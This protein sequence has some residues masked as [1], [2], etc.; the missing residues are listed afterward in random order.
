VEIDA[1]LEN[2][3]DEAAN[4]VR[5][6][7]RSLRENDDRLLVFILE[8]AHGAG[9]GVGTILLSKEL[10]RLENN[11]DAARLVFRQMNEVVK[12][13]DA[14]RRRFEQAMR[15]QGHHEFLGEGGS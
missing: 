13:I 2:A 12:E 6:A 10:A 11:D 15:E 8:R 9:I 14:S 4:E 1:N 3:A 5:D 7:I